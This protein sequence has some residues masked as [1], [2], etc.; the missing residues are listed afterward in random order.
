MATIAFVSLYDRNANGQRL[1]SANL[2]RHGHAC[3]IVF[4][5]R[6]GTSQGQFQAGPDEYPWIGI[7]RRGRPYSHACHEP[8][9]ARELELLRQEIERIRPDLIGMTVN[10]PLRTQHTGVTRFL[11]SFS[12]APVVWGGY[13]PTV[14]P[15]QCLEICDYACIGEGD[16]TILE[17]AECV[18]RGKAF[19]QVRNLA[20]RR[21][22]R[23]VF[24][25]RAPL[26][27]D[28]DSVPWRD[29]EPENKY[30]IEDGRIE[31]NYAVPND[32]P[33]GSYQTMTARGCPYSCTYCC[34]ASLKSLYS[35][36]R[37]L[38]RRSPE[39][40][41]D[42]LAQAKARF[43]LS[44]IV[45][46]DEIFGMD[47]KWLSAFVPLYRAKVNLP[48]IAYIYPARNVETLLPL[49]KQAGLKFCCVA[50]ESGSARINRFVFN[51]VFDRELFLKTIRLCRKLRL[52]F[53]TD[54]ITYNPYEEE[55]DLEDTLDVLLDMGGR[56]ELCINKLFVLPGTRLAERMLRDGV[57]AGDKSRDRLFDYYS[58][59]FWAATFS[60]NPRWAV[61]LLRWARVFRR[62]P[63]WL[64]LGFVEWLV[65]GP[66]GHL[67]DR[68]QWHLEDW[69]WLPKRIQL[70]IQ[71]NLDA[72]RTG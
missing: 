67:V 42:E 53:Y 51:R 49:L 11:K 4:L 9:S 29:N 19:D 44:E 38:R 57:S 18:D 43:N 64:H 6:Y 60:A 59:L 70:Q 26:V 58:R 31:E 48:F 20:Y 17:L 27:R 54:V 52:Y 66:V 61:R 28:L 56:F 68:V 32:R 21:D 10:T 72:D 3:H 8:V 50:L 62:H 12:A 40:C 14:N 55:R 47:L 5:K 36:E 33:A 45:F 16:T 39:S 41:V 65:G 30:F 69:G 34:E 24:N 35:G 13:D 63:R 2:K 7:D 15:E 71:E 22:G 1:L 37:F 25:P 46:E 23:P